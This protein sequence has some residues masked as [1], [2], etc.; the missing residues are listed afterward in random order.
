MDNSYRGYP[1]VDRIYK[2]GKVTSPGAS[3]LVHGQVGG[4]NGLSILRVKETETDIT[5]FLSD[6]SKIKI[7]K[8]STDLGSAAFRNVLEGAIEDNTESED[9]VTVKQIL[10]YLAAQT[11][12]A[13]E[14]GDLG[15][16]P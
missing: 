15:G 10:D 4:Q 5:L 9:L 8:A 1:C 13:G 12:G 3:G 7:N 11:D 2:T 6:G 14:W 16:T